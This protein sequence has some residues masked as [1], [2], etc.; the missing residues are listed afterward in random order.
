MYVHSSLKEM[1]WRDDVRKYR[2]SIFLKNNNGSIREVEFEQWGAG[3][4]KLNIDTINLK[5]DDFIY[6]PYL[7]M[8]TLEKLLILKRTL[9]KKYYYIDNLEIVIGYFSYSRQERETEKEPELAT[10]ILE[11][12]YSNFKENKIKVLEYHNKNSLNR[13]YNIKNISILKKLSQEVIKEL[14]NIYIV[15]P[16]K[17][18][19]TR[20][21][22]IGIES[23]IVINKVRK[24]GKV[25]SEIG[26]IKR[27]IVDNANFIILDDICDGGR[28]FA[29]ISEV[30]KRDYPNS[31]VTLCVAHCIIP[32][33]VK[34]LK[35][36][37]ID[38]IITSDTCMNYYFN[39]YI[40]VLNI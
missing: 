10:M 16:D 6:V 40:K 20:N 4:F 21:E 15:A 30:L 34:L 26:E 2:D 32:F 5:E 14:P 23:D 31:K 33:G 27:G 35:E 22:G 28:T 7:T 3:E 38:N 36:K 1:E 18:A 9:N 24:D 39:D 25:F 11:I 19:K 8:K 13:I 12:L 37:G 29:N 17:G